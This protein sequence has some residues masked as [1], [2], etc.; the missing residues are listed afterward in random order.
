MNR[1][2]VIEQGA[3]TSKTPTCLLL[4][5]DVSFDL[6]GYEAMEK[7]SNLQDEREEKDHLFFKHFKMTLQNEEHTKARK[8]LLERIFFFF[9]SFFNLVLNK[10][11]NISSQ[12]TGDDHFSPDD[13]QWVLTVPAIW[14]PSAKQFMREAAYHIL[15]ICLFSKAGVGSPE[16]P[17]Q[18]MMLWSQKRLQF[19]VKRNISV[20]FRRKLVV[21][22]RMAYYHKLTHTTLSW[23]LD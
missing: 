16:N 12:Q 7:Y 6:F 10:V 21:D 9:F 14:T 15:S 19:S 4:K 2:W 13:V 18:L 22:L 17:D 23:T 11:L 20:I 3:Q 8:E 5:S 1:D